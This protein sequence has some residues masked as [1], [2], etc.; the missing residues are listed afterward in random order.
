MRWPVSRV[1]YRRALRL[2]GGDHLSATAVAGSLVRSTRRLGRAALERLR[3][4]RPMRAAGL[5]TLLRAGFT[6]PPRSPWTLVRSYRTVSPL[7]A[8]VTGAGGLFSV[9]LS[10]GSP[11]VGVTH[12]PALWSPDFPRRRQ[13]CPDADAAARPPH[14]RA[15]A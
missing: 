1:L 5:L 12:R 11:R 9:A 7:P 13:G 14:P 4:L 2:A 8:S 3:G 10:R 6:E 15:S